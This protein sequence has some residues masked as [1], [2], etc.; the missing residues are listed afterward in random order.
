[1]A[2]LLTLGSGTPTDAVRLDVIRTAASIVLGTGGA[3]ALLLPARRQRAT[4]LDLV[5]RTTPRWM[6]ATTQPSAASPS[7]TPRPRTQLGSEN[8][9]VRLA[10][11]YALERLAQDNKNQRQTIVNVICAHLQM[12][13]TPPG[14]APVEPS[15]D[16]PSFQHRRGCACP[17]RPPSWPEGSIRGARDA[18]GRRLRSGRRRR[19]RRAAGASIR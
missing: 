6:L 3:A 12:P 8:A 2:L 7:C 9:P 17:G 11:L 1:V 18:R 5:R 4:E 16:S 14:L 13:Y 10:G 15:A 19:V